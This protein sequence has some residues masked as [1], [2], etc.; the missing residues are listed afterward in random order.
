ML[1][2]QEA[3]KYTPHPPL[4]RHPCACALA[5]ANLERFKT[6]AGRDLAVK[7][8]GEAL[9]S[10]CSWWDPEE[11]AVVVRGRDEDSLG[12]GG[13][14]VNDLLVVLPQGRSVA[15][16]LEKVGSTRVSCLVSRVCVFC[17]FADGVAVFR[18]LACLGC[19][20]SVF[21]EF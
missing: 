14:G 5:I 21:A 20:R 8:S 16:V 10:Y 6:K 1:R 2:K 11:V 3:R 12:G 4:P 17:F 7:R 18:C 19:C 13:S 15:D 9:G